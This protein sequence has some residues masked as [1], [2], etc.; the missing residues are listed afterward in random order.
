MKPKVTD[1]PGAIAPLW[2]TLR[3][4]TFGPGETSTPFH[5]DATVVPLGYVHVT[6]QPRLALEPVLWTV[7]SAWKPPVHEP[8]VR[9]VAEHSP[10]DGSEGVPGG[11]DG[12][13]EDGGSVP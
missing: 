13:S 6:V 9:R 10:A 8:R 7:T 12:G 1:P 3:T 2:S 11:V 4:P 5:S